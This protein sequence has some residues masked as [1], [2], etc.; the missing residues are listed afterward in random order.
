M[1]RA[2]ASASRR[3]AIQGSRPRCLALS[4]RHPL[5]FPTTIHRAIGHSGAA[6]RSIDVGQRR[7]AEPRGP[8]AGVRHSGSQDGEGRM[9]AARPARLRADPALP[10]GACHS[11]EFRLEPKP[12]LRSRWTSMTSGTILRGDHAAAS[13]TTANSGASAAPSAPSRRWPWRHSVRTSKCC[14]DRRTMTCCGCAAPRRARLTVSGG[15]RDDRV[16]D[17]ATQRR[18]GAPD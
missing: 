7:R 12:P 6:L 8:V 15:D 1:G 4:L 9:Y 13:V 5:H 18:L 3:P 2:R 11:R 16:H 17:Y 14:Q 10:S